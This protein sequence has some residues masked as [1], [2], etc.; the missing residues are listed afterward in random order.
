MLLLRLLLDV[1]DVS[2]VPIVGDLYTAS[3]SVG[4]NTTLPGASIAEAHS[5][6]DATKTGTCFSAQ[7][8][9]HQLQQLFQLLELCNLQIFAAK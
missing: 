7:K 4:Q 2:A 5:S 6:I 8:C 3:R 9:G 1:C